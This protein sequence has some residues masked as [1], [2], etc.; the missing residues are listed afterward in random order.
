MLALKLTAFSSA[1]VIL[2][3]ATNSLIARRIVS[4][5]VRR[6]AIYVLTL[7]SLGL[8]GEITFDTLYKFFVNRPLWEY[9]LL[10][11]HGGFTSIYSLFLWGVVGF[12]LYLLHNTLK[13]KDITS[14]HVLAA[15]FCLEAIALEALVNISY[16]IFFG[17]YIYYYLPGDLAHI[18][19]LQTLPLYLLAGYITVT[20]LHHANSLPRLSTMGNGLV[21]AAILLLR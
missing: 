3:Y 8:F 6:L 14:T 12:H 4:I 21:L 17:G 2:I 11:I 5:D 13:R 7:S 16:R 20:A 1:W 9:H 15:L 10:P 18:T 19:S